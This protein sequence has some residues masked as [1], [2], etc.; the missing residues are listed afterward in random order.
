MSGQND[1]RRCEAMTYRRNRCRS[2]AVGGV[3]GPETRWVVR[4]ACRLHLRVTPPGWWP[5]T[6]R[7]R[8][9]R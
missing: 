6:A 3:C 9:A 8:A 2:D 4:H 5:R 1:R 7:G